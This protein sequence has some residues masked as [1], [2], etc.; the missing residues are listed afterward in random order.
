MP[1]P[2]VL[3]RNQDLTWPEVLNSVSAPILAINEQGEVC[4]ANRAVADLVGNSPEQVTGMLL[5]NLLPPLRWEYLWERGSDPRGHLVEE[6]VCINGV[7]YQATYSKLLDEQQRLKAIVIMLLDATALEDSYAELARVKSWQLALES[8]FQSAYEGMIVINAEGYITMVNQ[9]FASILGEDCQRLIGKHI[10][11]AYPGNSQVSRLTEVIKTG[12]AEIGWLHRLNDQEVVV[13]RIPI[14]NRGVIVGAVAKIIFRNV[15]ELCQLAE[16]LGENRFRRETPMPMAPQFDLR[17]I[18]GNSQPMR[19]LKET[20]SRVASSPSTV[21]IIGESGTGKEIVAH[22]LHAESKRRLRPFVKVNCAAVPENL[23]ESE[24]FGYREGAFT[25]AKKGGKIGKFELANKGTIFLDEIGDMSLSMQAKLLRVLQEKEI[26]RLGDSK[27]LPVDVRIIAA[28][29]RNLEELIRTGQFREDLY[30]RLNVVTLRLLPLRE[31]REDIK[32]LIEYFINKFN[33]EF[34]QN[35]TQVAPDVYSLFLKYHWPGNVRELE[36]VLEQS[37]NVIEG[38]VILPKHLPPA[39]RQNVPALPAK[40][41]CAELNLQKL[42]ANTEKE[43]IIRA[44]AATNGNKVQ[45]A[46][47]LGISRAGLYQK[48]CRHNI[49]D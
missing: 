49:S 32:D 18:I 45:A 44:L 41:S 38:S 40:L 12:Q 23:L 35:V 25:G 29:N 1:F 13:S 43:A 33:L 24:L 3:R 36:N 28:T 2:A 46:A 9:A 5:D 8:I 4:L 42:L 11:E 27:P 14:R 22:A 20:I 34:G 26:E 17:H 6:R 48:L 7:V 39:L 16:K 31:R 37:F 10:H 30:Y 21:L 19:Q 47:L 15:Q